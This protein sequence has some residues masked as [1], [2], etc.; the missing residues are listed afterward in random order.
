MMKSGLVGIAA[1]LAMAS[2]KVTRAS[3]LNGLE[4]PMWL[5][6]TWTKLNGAARRVAAA[7]SRPIAA[8]A[9]PASVQTRPAPAQL[10]HFSNPRR[11]SPPAS[12]SLIGASIRF[13]EAGRGGRRTYSR[14]AVFSAKERADGHDHLRRQDRDLR[15]PSAGDAG[16]RRHRIERDPLR[17]G[18]RAARPRRHRAQQLRGGAGP[19]GRAL[20]AA[21]GEAGRDLRRLHRRAAERA[22]QLR[23]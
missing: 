5:S 9:P 14:P 17:P 10:M 4:K 3:G 19:P 18:S 22:T 6:L 21:D 12:S 1:I 20:A 11:L 2:R 7:A 23:S 16:A 15:R 13:Q 8:G